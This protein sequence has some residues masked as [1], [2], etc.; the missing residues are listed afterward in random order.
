MKLVKNDTQETVCEYEFAG[1]K[2]MLSP[3]FQLRAISVYRYL[4]DGLLKTMY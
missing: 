2:G 4:A 1:V 3:K